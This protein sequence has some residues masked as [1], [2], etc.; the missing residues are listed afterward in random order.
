M[1]QM[2]PFNPS[3]YTNSSAERMLFRTLRLMPGTGS[4]TVL[5]SVNIAN[6]VSQSQGEAD[7]IVVIPDEGIYVLEVK[8]GGVSRIDGK[9]VSRDRYGINNPIKNPIEE[10]NNAMYSIKNHVK[11]ETSLYDLRSTLFGFGVVF[12]NITYHGKVKNIEI[13]DEEVADIDDV[14]TPEN[15]KEYLLRLAAYWKNQAKYNY[16]LPTVKQCESIV[17]LIRPNIDGTVSLKSLIHNTENQI[18]E[19][20]KEQQVIFD[21]GDEND[22]LVIRGCAGSGKTILAINIANT[23]VEQ[24]ERVGLFCYNRKLAEYLKSH[25]N[26]GESFVCDS[27][28]EYMESVVEKAGKQTD[29]D[30]TEKDKYYEETLPELFREAFKELKMEPFD[31]LIL[32]E[33]Q[34]LIT[35]KYLEAMDTV[36]K[37]GLKEGN[38]RFFMDAERQNIFRHNVDEND[39][40]NLIKKHAGYYSKS[41][42]DKNCRNSEAILEKINQVFGTMTERAIKFDRGAEVSVKSYRT[43]DQADI[44][45][46]VLKKLFDEGIEE[47]QIVILSPVIY[48][49]SVA[50]RITEFPITTNP[51]EHGK[52]LFST[53]QG[54]K[55]L[56]SEVV[57]LTDIDELSKENYKRNLYVGMTRAK[58]VLFILASEKAARILR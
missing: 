11:N 56:E 33:A 40:L 32:D 13:A 23:K 31:M 58:S 54:Y 48:S 21:S 46:S 39:V 7:F 29:K 3:P 6:H 49:H 17:N 45:E 37:G 15:M 2:I 1:A 12:P 8:G 19:L 43:T 18:I 51:D 35:D 57:I 27:F 50:S 20:T 26:L 14:M 4:W 10:A 55:G 53:I 30:L 5:H 42:L 25:T 16:N 38:W 44:L 36:L 22:K 34:D 52:V 41:R 24:G 28:T 47:K 9:W